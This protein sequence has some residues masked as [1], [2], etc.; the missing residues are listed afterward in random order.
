V[1][2]ELFQNVIKIETKL[3][4]NLNN[5]KKIKLTCAEQLIFER[6]YFKLLSVTALGPSNHQLGLKL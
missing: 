4:Q 2:I 5:L 3:Y 6:A 1:D